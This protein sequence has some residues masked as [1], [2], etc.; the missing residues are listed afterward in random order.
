MFSAILQRIMINVN[1]RNVLNARNSSGF[2]S[3]TADWL[4]KNRS[5]PFRHKDRRVGTTG[6]GVDVTEGG[7]LDADTH[8]TLG[9]GSLKFIVTVISC[10]LMD[11]SWRSP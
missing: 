6:P 11:E 1:H 10:K 2:S 5:F 7:E 3:L 8:I 9:D 4:S